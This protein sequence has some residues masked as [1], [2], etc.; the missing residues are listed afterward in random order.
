MSRRKILVSIAFV[1]VLGA[2]AFFF[3]V[4]AVVESFLNVK[5]QAPP[6]AASE[7]ARALHRGLFV[8]DMHADSLLW[9]RDILE[10]SS[11]G[12]VDV[13]RLAEGGVALQA[14][15]I[16][17]KSPRGLNYDAN[18]GDTDNITPLVFAQRW[19]ARTWGSLTERALYQARKLEDAAA[20]SGGRLVFIKS[21]ADLARFVGKRKD[22]SNAVGAFLGVEGAHA[23]DGELGNVERLYDAGVRMM[24]PTHFFDNE[25]GGSAH[26]VRKGGLTERGRE[27]VRLMES[28]RMLVDLAH[29]SPATFDEVIAVA[30]RPVVVSHTGVK[31]TCESVRNLSDEQLRRVAATG[32]VVGIG[33]WDTATCGSDAASIARAIRHAA[34][35][36]GA[37]HVALGSDFDGTVTTPF[38]ATGVVQITDALLA[39]GFG[40]DDIRLIMGGNVLRLLSETLPPT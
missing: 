6:Y 31:G 34:S 38:D 33:F 19:P 8:A 16:V 26:G 29:A 17:T 13:P 36:V 18:D 35:V 24:A 11:R 40:E 32:G 10:R 2:A 21:A 22:G 3:V 27:L 14:F 12:H 20:R 4:P 30:S 1:V 28:K 25:W 37:R 23:L 5:T 39:A 7:R 9:D 15:T